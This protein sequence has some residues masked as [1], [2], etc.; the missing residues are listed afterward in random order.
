[1]W[2]IM[3]NIIDKKSPSDNYSFTSFLLNSF[4]VL[5]IFN[6]YSNILTGMAADTWMLK[7]TFIEIMM[8][9]NVRYIE[10]LN[11]TNL[12]HEVEFPTTRWLPIIEEISRQILARNIHIVT[13]KQS[14][15]D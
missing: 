5:I 8:K 11:I 2:E 13:I 10:D 9:R 1:M 15:T 3:H 14:N 12:L 4:Y 7:N 6:K